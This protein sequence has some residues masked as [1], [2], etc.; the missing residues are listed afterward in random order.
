MPFVLDPSGII[1][2]ATAIL[3]NRE[4]ITKLGRKIIRNLTRRNQRILVLG[5]GG[6]GKT[7]LGKFFASHSQ[8]NNPDVRNITYAESLRSEKFQFDFESKA[9]VVIPP[10]Q[11]RHIARHLPDTFRSLSNGKVSGI[12]NVVS[13]GYHSMMI[14]SYKQFA[15][16][17]DG[18][19]KDEVFATYANERKDDELKLLSKLTP[20]LIAN[21]KRFWMLTLVSKQD[22]W[23]DEQKAV[24]EYYKSGP[25]N[26]LI[27]QIQQKKG[28]HNFRHEFVSASL[29]INNLRSGDGDTLAQTTAG[30]DE[31]TKL[32]HLS[33]LLR[34]VDEML[35]E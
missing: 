2:F 35:S 3:D 16:H 24:E 6:V 21:D 14:D 19:S 13:Y 4:K 34:V 11:E 9:T 25:Y 30:Y 8:G 18:M 1:S 12:I 10:G 17:Q 7:T 20:F 27:M 15:Q 23:W 26:D 32:A 5:A 33:H 22:L 28:E 31:Y 29:L